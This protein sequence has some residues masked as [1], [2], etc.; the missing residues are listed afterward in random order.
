MVPRYFHKINNNESNTFKDMLLQPEKSD[1]IICMIK[2]VEEHE[3]ISHWTLTKKGEVNN[4]HKNKY[5]KLNTILYIWSFNRKIFPN[6]ILTRHKPR[7]CAYGGMK[8]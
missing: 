4:K 3:A 2:E 5:G 6:G 8:Q 7:L 1:F